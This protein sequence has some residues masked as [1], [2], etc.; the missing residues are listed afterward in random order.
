[1][2]EVD[3]VWFWAGENSF[4]DFIASGVSI[5]YFKMQSSLYTII[6]SNSGCCITLLPQAWDEKR[7]VSL[8]LEKRGGE[9]GVRKRRDDGGMKFTH[10]F[11]CLPPTSGLL[12]PVH[13]PLNHP[14]SEPNLPSTY[15]HSFVHSLLHT[16]EKP[17]QS[18][19]KFLV[20]SV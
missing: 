19:L 14:Q 12:Y 18:R 17:C 7:R 10:S 16:L 13:I 15:S 3:V 4:G 6:S 9:R 1:M 5:G 11:R 8:H 2:L 20:C